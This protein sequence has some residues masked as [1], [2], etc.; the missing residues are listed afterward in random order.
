MLQ[1]VMG[2]TVLLSLGKTQLIIMSSWPKLS[3]WKLLN[4]IHN[5]ITVMLTSR[6]VIPIRFY[7]VRLA[8]RDIPIRYLPCT[9]CLPSQNVIVPKADWTIYLRLTNPSI[10]Y[11][12]YQSVS[13]ITKSRIKY[14][15]FPELLTTRL[16]WDIVISKLRHVIAVSCYL[17]GTL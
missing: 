15:F 9:V 1:V 10:Y 5:Y 8:D 3:I 16:S 6:P 2:D 12:G 4:W 14:Y 11:L 17:L 7:H 13:T